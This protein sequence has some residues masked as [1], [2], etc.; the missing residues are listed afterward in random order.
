MKMKAFKALVYQI[1]IQKI[2]VDLEDLCL[3]DI[4]FENYF[5]E[6]F[7]EDEAKNAAEDCACFIPIRWRMK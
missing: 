4:D 1:M 5:D 3:P 2:G 6:D 7:T